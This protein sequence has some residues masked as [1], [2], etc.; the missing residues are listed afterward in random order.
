MSA[1]RAIYRK[2]RLVRHHTYEE[3][4]PVELAE[5]LLEVTENQRAICLLIANGCN[6]QEAEDLADKLKL[7]ATGR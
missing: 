4:T 1:L 5:A 6:R 7:D 3:P 2:V